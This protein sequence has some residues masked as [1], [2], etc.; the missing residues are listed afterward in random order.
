MATEIKCEKKVI[1]EIF[2]MWYCIP[3]Y[4]RAYVW[5]TDQVR[6]LLDD[7]ISA[8]RENKEAQYFLGS[9]VLKINEKSENNVSYTEYE[10]LDGQQRITTV[11]LIL[12]CMRDMLTD[13]PQYQNSLAGFVYQAEDAILQQPERMRII[14]NIRSDV[15]D[16]VNEHIKPLHGTCDSALLKDKMQAKDVNISIRNMANAMLVAHEFLEENKNEIIGYL[17]YFLNKVLMI[18]VATEELQDAFQL[19]TVLNN[20]GVKLSSS[21]I[22]KAENL[23][24][25]SAVDRTSWATR[26][27]EMETYFGEDF[28]KFLSHIRTILVKKKQTTTLLKEFDEFVYSNQEY[29]RTQKKY[30][31]RTPIL[32]RGRDTFELLYSYYHT[33]QEVFDTDHSVVTGDYEITNYLKL[34]ETGFGADYWIAPVLDY[35]RKYRRRGFVAFLK[36]LDRKLSAD[37]ITAATPTVR[38][39]NV[40]AI[41][42]EIEASQDSAALL[43]SKT[44]TIN[45]SD[46][47]RVINGDIYGRSFAKYLL[48]KLDL[49]YRGSSTPMIPQAIA[50]IEHILPRN[51]SAD[52]QWVKDFS[53]AEREEWTNKL[54]NLV[55]I[56][57]R[58]NTSQGNRDY[59][60]KKEK[61]FERNIEMF[62]NSI[63][64]YQNYPEWKLSDLKKNHSD[65]VTELLNVY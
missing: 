40:N 25:L 31:P 37:W 58:K 14:F 28:D 8:Y 11:F 60:E 3:D 42:R 15:R 49:I 33:Y 35:Y 51:P 7:T 20:R 30:V 22:L 6:D 39:E 9:M 21:D 62:P 36:A 50:S 59:V 43:Q 57:R 38:M 13:Y 10:L 55:L 27:E 1:R 61:Y 52:S 5:D 56:S 63:R 4:Q 41:L 47:E 34:M 44:F 29:D 23:K 53:A 24:E 64:I 19:F 18:Y 65:V 54:G 2:N 26:W 48:L 12:A 45:K 17:S 16:F 46:F 32:R